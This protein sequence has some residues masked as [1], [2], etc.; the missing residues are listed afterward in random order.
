MQFA[1]KP[2][3]IKTE[4][5]LDFKG[6]TRHENNHFQTHEPIYRKLYPGWVH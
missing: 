6:Y 5:Q 3:K 2:N 1:K 4:A